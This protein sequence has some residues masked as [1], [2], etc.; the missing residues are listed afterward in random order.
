MTNSS[1]HGIAIWVGALTSALSIGCGGAETTSNNGTAG[2]G[3][4][5]TLGGTAGTM[6]GTAGSFATAGTGT[7][8]SVGGTAGT[9]IAGSVGGTAGTGAID[10]AVMCASEVPKEGQC[11]ATAEGVYALKVAFDVWWMDE[12]TVPYLI[13]PGRGTIEVLFRGEI[14]DVC[15]DG[16]DGIGTLHPCGSTVPPFLVGANCSAVHIQ[17]PEDL[18]DKPGI[19]DYITKGN[20]TGFN[21]GDVLSIAQ[22]TGLLGIELSDVNGPFPAHTETT[23]FTC[24]S[25]TLEQC[26]PDQDGDGNPGVTVNFAKTGMLTPTSAPYKSPYTCNGF[27]PDWTISEPPIAVLAVLPTPDARVSDA[28]VGMKLSAGGSG[29]IA[30]DCASGVGD[31]VAGDTIPTRVFACTKADGTPCSG[32]DATFIDTNAP[33]YHVLKKGEAPPATWKHPTRPEADA[34]LDR[35]TSVG[36]RSSVVR[37]G[38][39]GE[40]KTCGDIRAATFP[41]FE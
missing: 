24:P 1:K 13:E 7:A 8:G 28:Y 25:G 30:A 9:G 37:I 5:G 22:T 36:P 15:E 40:A 41:A 16:S 14:S 26:F 17:F 4:A 29:K 19:P 3:N 23:T 20:A 38:N 31:A 39:L 10:P 21:P 34:V 18:W 6:V 2:F 12:I 35:S 11:K 32:A 27:T 33:L